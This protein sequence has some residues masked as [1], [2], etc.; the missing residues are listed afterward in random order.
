MMMRK[1]TRIALAAGTVALGLLGVGGWFGYQA[2]TA[3]GYGGC[4]LRGYRAS[5]AASTAPHADDLFTGRVTSF[6]ERRE[7]SASV[8]D[9]YLV[10][11]VSV[12]RGDLHGTVRVTYGLDSGRTPRLA[13]GST[14]VFATSA[15]ED[16]HMQL[17]QGAMRPVDDVQLALWRRL[18]ALP[19]VKD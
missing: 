19:P 7:F 13:D 2:W 17:Y 16:G 11:V 10:E 15:W 12:L 1:K 14:Y 5:D 3:P 6:E 18:A 4:S 9:V 8:Q